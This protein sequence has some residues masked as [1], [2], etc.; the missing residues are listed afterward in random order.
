MT[1]QTERTYFFIAGPPK[2]GTT[3][4]MRLMDAHPESA[5]SGEGHY[6]D[7]LRPL[8]VDVFKKYQQLLELDNKLVFMDKPVL[9]PI[10]QRHINSLVRQFVLDR[11][12]EHDTDG[13]ARAHGDKTPNNWKDISSMIGAFPEARL[14]YITRDP[15]DA[16]VSL[17]GH[18]R[19]RQLYKMD[20]EGPIDRKRLIEASCTN[21]NGSIRSLKQVRDQIPDR[22][23][24]VRYEDLLADTVGEYGRICGRLGLSTD[25]EVLQ[26]AVDACDF[27]KLSGRKAGEKDEKSFFTSGTSGG[28]RTELSAAEATMV[29]AACAELMPVAGYAE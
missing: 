9:G 23:I 24:E 11:F 15:R 20:P 17:F 25:P 2:G 12:A 16:A 14:I 27:Q 7:R 8:L 5:C 29:V 26:A 10:R 21:W 1:D 13:K 19:R 4:L 18:A 3:W 22:L 28:W 6:F